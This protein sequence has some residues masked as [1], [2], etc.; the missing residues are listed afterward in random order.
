M[1]TFWGKIHISLPIRT[2]GKLLAATSKFCSTIGKLMIDELL[3]ANG[4]EITSTVIGND[5]S[6]IYW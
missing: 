1:D 3:A 4:E 5:V 6:G 2:N